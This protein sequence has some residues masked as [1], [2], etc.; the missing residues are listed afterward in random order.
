MSVTEA[1]PM[2]DPQVVS[3]LDNLRTISAEVK[4]IDAELGT[5]VSGPVAQRNKIASQY[6]SQ[7]T[8]DAESDVNRFVNQMVEILNKPDGFS[9]SDEK[10]TA[11]IYLL[12]DRLA[13]GPGSRVTEFLK[14]QVDALPKTETP[15]VDDSRKQELADR[16]SNIT[17][18]FKL[19]N[20]MLK[21]YGV[22][23]LPSDI[24]APSIRR[25][26]VGPRVKLNKTYQFYVDG[27]LKQLTDED[28][29]KTNPGLS[30]IA[31]TVTKDLNWKTKQLRD[32]IVENVGGASVS[33][34]G[35]EITLP[36]TWEVT[37]PAPVNKTLRG[38]AVTV[39]TADT[40]VDDSDD[41]DDDGDDNGSEGGESNDFQM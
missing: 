5:D 32:F 26:A 40:N 31:T 35:D 2:T 25:G 15:T 11:V 21:Y 9:N 22:T 6:V 20:E 3:I 14:K 38:V 7:F 1:S 17:N 33:E 30:Y 10:L 36:D 37:L 12:N 34:K 24:E 39:V 4:Q 41:G 29:N 18:I 8:Q 28:G 27:K 23:E 16:R 13:K 19:Q